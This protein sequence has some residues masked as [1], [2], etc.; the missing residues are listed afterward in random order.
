MKKR[1]SLIIFMIAL[2]AIGL[3]GYASLGYGAH[4]ANYPNPYPTN[5]TL[6]GTPIGPIVLKSATGADITVGSSTPY[7]PKQ[8]CGVCHEYEGTVTNIT[9]DHGPGTAAYTVKAPL[10]GVT[11]GYH[12]QQGRN[13]AWN[14]DNNNAQRTNYGLPKFTSSPGMYGKF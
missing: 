9:K 3:I 12:F 14:S 4:P 2:M 5:P 11:A 1:G 6:A 7:S 10:S 8:T 13:V